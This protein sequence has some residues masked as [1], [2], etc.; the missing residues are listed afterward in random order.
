MGSTECQSSLLVC[1]QDDAKTTYRIST[2]L[3]GRMGHGPRM[4][5]LQF[6]VNLDKDQFL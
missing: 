4:N 6:V 1:K 3:V 2:K 5:L